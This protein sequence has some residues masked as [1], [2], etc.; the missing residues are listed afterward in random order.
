[1]GKQA[2]MAQ[3][4]DHARPE[5]RQA[6][7]RVLRAAALARPEVSAND[8]WDGLEA[9]GISTHDNRASGPVMVAAAKAGW[10]VRTDRTITTSR[11]SRHRGDVRV[12][13]SLLYREP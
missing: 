13:Q 4:W 6:A 1:V 9:E 11:P 7:L 3:V 8:L 12:W 5:F 2:G 10:I